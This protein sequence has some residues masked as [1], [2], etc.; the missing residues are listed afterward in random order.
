MNAGEIEIHKGIPIPE[1]VGRGRRHPIT[2]VMARMEEGD[3]IDLPYKNP[4]A[5]S[6]LYTKAKTAKIKITMRV[7]E[8][9]GAKIV[10]VWRIPNAIE[11]P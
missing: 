6:E 11:S 9:N 10:R 3:S 5:K 7:V 8:L 2:N 1:L 4:K